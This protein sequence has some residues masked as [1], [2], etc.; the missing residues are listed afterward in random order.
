MHGE[1]VLNEKYS[2][3][4]PTQSRSRWHASRG[5]FQKNGAIAL[6]FFVF[7]ATGLLFA[8]EISRFVKGRRL[9]IG[10]SDSNYS[11]QQSEGYDATTYSSSEDGST[12]DLSSQN[13]YPRNEPASGL[14]DLNQRAS[15]IN[16]PLDKD[17]LTDNEG[18][19]KNENGPVIPPERI[20][21]RVV[22]TRLLS[23]DPLVPDFNQRPEFK[24]PISKALEESQTLLKVLDKNFVSARFALTNY[25]AGLNL[26]LNLNTKIINPRELLEHV[27][28]LDLKVT[29]AFIDEEV[30]QT[31]YFIWRAIS[32]TPLVQVAGRTNQFSY[33]AP[34]RA[35]LV[36]T[37]VK[38]REEI[39][40]PRQDLAGRV[41]V[42]R[43]WR[44]Q[45]VGV[46][47]G[48]EAQIIEMY[49]GKTLSGLFELPKIPE[50]QQKVSQPNYRRFQFDFLDTK[51][52]SP[53]TIRVVNQQG[54]YVQ[55]S[56]SITARCIKFFEKNADGTFAI[57]GIVNPDLTRSPSYQ[58]D[59][60]LLLSPN[61][62]S[63]QNGSNVAF[64]PNRNMEFTTFDSLKDSKPF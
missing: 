8:P 32:L 45:L 36:L 17:D 22:L 24:V 23:S 21:E 11:N 54:S 35:D 49:Y 12:K 33:E 48:N 3:K 16:I 7:I 59:K 25:L 29:Q 39:T 44:L 10:K 38:M 47:K 14:D 55:K 43:A 51:G 6:V 60:L 37:S 34:F 30:S 18:R 53:F 4:E 19:E 40:Q 56:Y 20:A 5:A 41:P 52:S 2:L 58:L 9:R 27:G 13:G 61:I 42:K 46:V 50:Q 57:P 28:I 63:S 62:N 15:K 31:E 26:L 1:P 64:P